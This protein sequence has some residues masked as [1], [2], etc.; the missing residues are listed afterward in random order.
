MGKYELGKYSRYAHAKQF[1]RA[2]KSLR[3][4]KTFLGRVARD[5][6]RKLPDNSNA[7]LAELKLAERLIEQKKNSKNKIYSLHETSVACI[8][9]GKSHK[10]YEFG[11]KVSIATTTTTNWIVAAVAHEGSRYDGH[12]LGEV[13][14][15]IE[16]V[17]GIKPTD[18]FADKGYRGS[19]KLNPEVQVHISGTSRGKSKRQKKLLRRRSAIEPIIGHTKSENRLGRNF[20]KGISGDKFNALLAAC[21]R[22]VSKLLA[23]IFLFQI[24][25]NQILEI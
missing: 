16:K 17:V 1:K 15:R 3:K 19:Q 22:N 24:F 21:G 20:L 4:L 6:R 7:L 23:L 13:L 11:C 9:K 2:R 10:R 5:I 25:W 12:T 14:S 18:V 8:S